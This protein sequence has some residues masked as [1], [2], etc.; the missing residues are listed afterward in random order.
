MSWLGNF[1][2]IFLYNIV[3]GVATALSLT[4]KFTA[5]VRREIYNRL[6]S[7]FHRDGGGGATN[8]AATRER[9]RDRSVS[10]SNAS[11]PTTPAVNGN[12]VHLKEN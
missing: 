10:Y 3:F 6:G 8:A 5:A 1:Y 7:F 9:E 2:I 11:A 12:G 4:T